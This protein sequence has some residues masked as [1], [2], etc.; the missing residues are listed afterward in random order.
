MKT[1]ERIKTILLFVLLFGAVFLTYLNWT[2]Y[3]ANQRQDG[4]SIDLGDIS[5]TVRD[6]KTVAPFAI[7]HKIEKGRF[8]AAYNSNSVA[9]VFN[10]VQPLL[11]SAFNSESGV[12]KISETVWQD[13]LTKN[14]VL[15]DFEGNVPLYLIAKQVGAEFE[16][17]GVYGRYLLLTEN[18]LFLKDTDRGEYFAMRHD[19]NSADFS[20]LEKINATPCSL[21]A[22]LGGTR[23]SGETIVFD[24]QISSFTVNSVNV[25]DGF[26]DTQL[27]GLLKIFAMNYNTCGK[28]IDKDGSRVYVEDLNTL[29]IS[30]AGYVTYESEASD[31]EMSLTISAEGESP[32]EREAVEGADAIISAL[33]SL[34]GNDAPIYLRSVSTTEI[35]YGRSIGGIPIDRSESGYS[36]EVYLQGKRVTRL[37]FHLRAYQSSGNVIYTLPQKLAIA[38]VPGKTFA[39]ISLRYAD[40]GSG[41]MEAQWFVKK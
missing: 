6:Q 9:L 4:G 29:K 10:Q 40:T 15:V 32:T 2:S 38:S 5:G 21:A 11:L 33:M 41:G 20:N 3:T 36:A 34:A 13:E 14:G 1:K 27:A 7:T 37:N 19:L 23:A 17:E 31:D 24:N 18:G 35:K 12:S 28:H 16:R 26:T 39:I 8:G 22:E 30:P 25:T